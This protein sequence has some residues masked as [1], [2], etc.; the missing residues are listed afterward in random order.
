MKK[1]A[2]NIGSAIFHTLS[3]TLMILCMMSLVSGCA[4]PKE[5]SASEE[6][7]S[8]H[9]ESTAMMAPVKPADASIKESSALQEPSEEQ[10]PE[11]QPTLTQF[12]KT[13]LIP[14]DQ[15]LYVWG[16]GWNE[17]DTGGN[18]ETNSMGMSPSWASF[19]QENVAGY[20]FRDHA[21]QIHDGLDCSGYVGWTL[22][23]TLNEKRD[24]V[25][26]SWNCDE[27]LESLGLGWR[28]DASE[29]S[30][31]LPGDIM[32][33]DRHIYI[34]LGQYA[35]GSVLLMHSSPPGVRLSGTAGMAYET[36][37]GYQ[38]NPWDPLA[39]PSYLDYD[40]FRFYDGA[41]PDPDHLR[42]M[43]PDGVLYFLLT[44]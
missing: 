41:L 35:D 11:P 10:I 30:E 24:Y 25:T 28:K 4:G 27:M 31:I 9:R 13:A 20:Y 38:N 7:S 3:K 17:E 44:H 2:S 40:Q 26:N 32:T 15:V 29:V 36:A 43:N 18:Q 42:E 22:F 14:K 1:A 8:T 12:L 37:L 6:N 33:S 39:D 16:G 34:A 19:F 5:A 21:W 23:N